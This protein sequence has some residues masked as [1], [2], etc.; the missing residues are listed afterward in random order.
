M[1][2]GDQRP[3]TGPEGEAAARARVDALFERFIR[4]TPPALAHIGLQRPDPAQHR[5]RLQA[6]EA[7]ADASGRSV[8]L[9]EARAAAREL[10]L[11]R[12]GEGTLNPTWVGLNWVVSEGSAEDR[13]AVSLALSDAASAAVVEDL[14]APGLVEALSVDAEHVL[15]MAGGDAYEGALSRASQPPAPD[16]PDPPG[17]AVV[18]YGG[19]LI[20]GLMVAA[21]GAVLIAPP[22]GL[23][24]GVV[25]AMIL[26][27]YGRRALDERPPGT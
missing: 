6:V 2:E 8:L 7:A 14:V 24:G 11:G 18:V 10:V 27:A 20:G 23:A 4:L 9:G 12:N 1:S 13:A 19:A 22:I 25:F 17:R 21:S 3:D 15:G 5:A 26:V 16:L